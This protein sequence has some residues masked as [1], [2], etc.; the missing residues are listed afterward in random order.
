[1]LKS[2]VWWWWWWGED[3]YPNLKSLSIALYFCRLC[4]LE[5]LKERETTSQQRQWGLGVQDHEE[6]ERTG[7][8][9]RMAI[10]SRNQINYS[11]NTFYTICLLKTFCKG[12]RVN[13]VTKTPK[14]IST[15]TISFH[16]YHMTKYLTK[17]IYIFAE[18]FWPLKV[19]RGVPPKNDHPLSITPIFGSRILS[20]FWNREIDHLWQKMD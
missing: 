17:N 15:G 2:P 11:L 14:R 5:G 4:L 10:I 7:R 8:M 12:N 19:R 18:V 3:R 1:M 9:I 16:I 13:H 20:Y 6:P